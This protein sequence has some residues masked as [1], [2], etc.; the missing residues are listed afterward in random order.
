MFFYKNFFEFK[1]LVIKYY[2]CAMSQFID[3]SA[4]ESVDGKEPQGKKWC[5][6]LNNY[7]DTEYEILKFWV[8]EN[9]KYAI[10]GKEV[11]KENGVPHIQGVIHCR[12]NKRLSALKKV[13]S[14]VHWEVQRGTDEEAITYCVKE[15]ND[16]WEWGT[17]PNFKDQGEPQYDN[18]W[19][20]V[21]QS[22]AWNQLTGELIDL[23]Y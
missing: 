18:G 17:R 8:T 4:N 10:L 23:M 16:A 14:R 6:T 13:N 21:T 22:V 7:S 19:W 3:L 15:D 2:C 12:G 1:S 20:V 11:G 5:L 9:C